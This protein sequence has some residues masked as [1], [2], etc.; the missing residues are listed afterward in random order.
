MTLSNHERAIRCQQAITAYSDDDPYTNFVDLLADALHWCHVNGHS[1]TDAFETAVIHYD[2]EMT[3]DDILNDFNHPSSNERN[4]T[5]TESKPDPR[6]AQRTLLRSLA[7]EA[8]EAFWQ[9]IVQRY[10]EA[11]TGDLSPL[12]T[13]R[14]QDAAENAI[15]EWIHANVPTTTNE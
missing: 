11:T 13:V 3:E 5:M 10:P 1:F 7:D 12:T 15:G 14:L 9:V 8:Q 6:E 2:A 4:Q